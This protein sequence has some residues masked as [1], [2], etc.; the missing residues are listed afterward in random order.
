M[1]RKRI[2]NKSTELESSRLLA[3]LAISALL[4]LSM[5]MLLLLPRFLVHL[6]WSSQ[7]IGWAMGCFFVVYL[8]AQILAG[9]LADRFGNVLIAFLGTGLAVIGALCYLVGLRWP[10]LFLLGRVFHGAGTAMVSAGVLFHLVQSVPLRLRGR[11]IGYFGLPGFVTL[12]AGPLL[13]EFLERHWGLRGV[14]LFILLVFLT[15]ASILRGLPRPLDSKSSRRESFIEGFRVNYSKLKPLLLFSFFFGFSFAVW[16]S[17][18]APAVSGLGPRA[19]P[20][21]GLGYGTGSITTRLGLSQSLETGRRRL[22]AISSL[23]LYGLGLA[24]V[25]LVSRPWQLGMLGLLCGMSHGIYYPALSSIAAERFH[26]LHTG[27]AMSLYTS[28]SSLGIFL[29]SPTWGF[30]AD[31]AGYLG[32]FMAAGLLLLVATVCFLALEFKRVKFVVER[33]EHPRENLRIDSD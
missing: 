7:K 23:V 6:G 3:Y 21:F 1:I 13:G 28:A 17:F 27:N 33:C 12:G 9:Y 10:D 5:W 4:S 11:I 18:L 22:G 32:I 2:V 19:V 14:F 29:G 25:P 30:F 26:P 8:V 24:L 31:R 15:I 20:A 16:Q